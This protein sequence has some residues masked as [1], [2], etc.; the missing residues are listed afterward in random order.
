MATAAQTGASALATPEQRLVETRALDIYR[1]ADIAAA[2]A[3][4]L[5]LFR[6][7]RNAKLADQDELIVR[8]V[9]EHYFHASLMAANETPGDPRFVW[10]LNPAHQWMG[11][12][13]PGSR[14]GQDNT[15]NIYRFASVDAARRYKV[16]GRFFA[17]RSSDFGICALPAQMGENTLAPILAIIVADN[18]DTDADG[19][20]EIALDATPTDG[21]RNHLCIADAKTL[22]VRDTLGDWT[23]E[24]PSWLFIEPV[25]GAP[26][27][28]FDAARAAVRAAQLGAAIAN[29]FLGY[30]QHDMVETGPVNAMAS[31]VA[32][33]GRGGLVTQSATLGYYRL[34]DNEAM[35]IDADRLGARYVGMQIVDMWMISYNYWSR[36]SSLNHSQAV[37]DSDG[38]YR[39]VISASDP[40]VH[41]WLDGSGAA[42]GAIL[43]RW[44]HLPPGADL[45]GSVVTEV[46][47]L[48]DL[49]THLPADTR[50]VDAAGRAAQQQRRLE[51][52]RRRVA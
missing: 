3:G 45:A 48:S 40:G 36:T 32:S 41:N 7:D 51:G 5:A 49:R 38:R 23:V 8:S 21:R 30:V 12:D 13:V 28:D 9:D 44:Q 10:T 24:S 4:T 19:R 39:W 52:F 22:M 37:P 14:F 2:K 34:G 43:L 33:A 29:F 35:V 6:A 25:D 11:L 18:I 16:T 15:D 20:F 50:Y 46:V 26:V 17:Q 31:P 1:R 27:D 42:T 47:K